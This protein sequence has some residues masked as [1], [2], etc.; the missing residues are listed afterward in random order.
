MSDGFETVHYLLEEAFIGLAGGG[1][2]MNAHLPLR[3][4]IPR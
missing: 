2:E 1:R 4:S 3:T